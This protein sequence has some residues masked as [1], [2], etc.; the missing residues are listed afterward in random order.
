MMD[1]KGYN[2]E[3]SWF[4]VE[5][6]L[7]GSFIILGLL[8]RPSKGL[9]L[10]TQSNPGLQPRLVPP[11]MIQSSLRWKALEN[12]SNQ[13]SAAQNKPAAGLRPKW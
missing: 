2:R 5:G 1:V 6:Y 10:A 12:L 7:S 3:A 4:L 11:Q 9:V 8:F 13:E